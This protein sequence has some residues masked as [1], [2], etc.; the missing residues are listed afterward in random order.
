MYRAVAWKALRQGLSL[1]D[2][3]AVGALARKCNI[4]LLGTVEDPRIVIDAT[5]VTGEVADPEVARAA[6]IVSAIPAVRRALV[7]RQQQMGAGGG[8]VME[9]RDI[10][11]RVFPEAE[12]KIFL[13]ASAIDRSRRRQG[14]DARR[15]TTAPL[16][17]IKAEIEE[18]DRRDATRDDS[19]LVISP[20]AHYLDSTGLSID[21]V[22]DRALRL[23]VDAEAGRN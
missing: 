8:V 1:D 10:G 5:D 11:S 23:V 4:Q 3:E 15:G 16:E 9:G 7:A 2:E 21:E 12:V 22:V 17:T 13:D 19:P 20:D 18:R 14:Q 6:S